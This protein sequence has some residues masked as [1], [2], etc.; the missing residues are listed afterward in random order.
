M[1]RILTCFLRLS[2]IRRAIRTDFIQR[3]IVT[4]YK[5]KRY[6]VVI[7]AIMECSDPRVY[8]REVEAMLRS[9]KP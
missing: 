3:M 7:E 4:S 5:G 1:V 6:G 2:W 9:F 8:I